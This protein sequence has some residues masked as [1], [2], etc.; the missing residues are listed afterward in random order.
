MRRAAAG[1]RQGS[2]RAAAG[3]RQGVADTDVA[4]A[5]SGLSTHREGMVNM[6]PSGLVSVMPHAWVMWW[7]VTSLNFL[8]SDKGTADPPTGSMR[9]CDRSLQPANNQSA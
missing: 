6:E 2:G 5:P 7:P 8:D 1:Q 4:A 9:R 3:K